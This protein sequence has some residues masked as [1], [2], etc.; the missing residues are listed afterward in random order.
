M[1]PKHHTPLPHDLGARMG[2]WQRMLRPDHVAT[3]GPLL[4]R[5]LR[6]V[7]ERTVANTNKPTS[8]LRG[9]DVSHATGGTSPAWIVVAVLLL[10]LCVAVGVAV[11]YSLRPRATRR[12]Q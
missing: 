3:C 1:E 5:G 8:S 12:R 10:V 2:V 6:H 9:G 7:R 11:F 4:P